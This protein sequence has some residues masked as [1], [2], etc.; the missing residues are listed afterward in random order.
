AP[1]DGAPPDIS[2]DGRYNADDGTP[3]RLPCTSKFGNQLSAAATYGRLDGYLVAI[4][5]PSNMNQCNADSSHVHLQIRMMGSVYDVA[6]DATDG[7]TGVDDV[8][9]GQLDHDLPDSGWSEGWHT[10]VVEDYVALGKHSTDLVLGTKAAN[11]AAMMTFL[12]TANHVSVYMTS[13]GP[14]GGHLVH[15][16]GTGHDGLVITAPLSQPAHLLM[17]AFD[18]QVF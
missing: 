3:T 11:V 1:S 10:G 2:T 7:Q 15:R 18:D 12:A 14:D 13:Y 16:N 17:F 5:P 9:T 4:V 6:I 8:H